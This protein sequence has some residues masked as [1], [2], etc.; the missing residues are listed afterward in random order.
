MNATKTITG[1]AHAGLGL[2]DRLGFIAPLATRIVI[3]LAYFQ[4]GLGKWQ[5]FDRTVEFFTSSGIPFPV[6]NVAL[7]ATLELI[8]GPLLIAGFMTRL[9]ASALSASMVVALLTA[10][11]ASFLAAWK[12][13]AESGPTDVAAFVFLLFLLWLVLIGPGVVSVDHWM[14]KKLEACGLPKE[15]G[16]H[17]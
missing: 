15:F 3:G 1:A 16:S 8:G 2:T 17:R 5:H 6:F 14:R 4:T 11:R 10:D 7:V 12:P 9:T 13:G